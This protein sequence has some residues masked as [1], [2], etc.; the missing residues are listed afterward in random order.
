MSAHPMRIMMMTAN[1]TFAL[2]FIGQASFGKKHPQHE[3]DEINNG[4]EDIM[5]GYVHPGLMIDVHPGDDNATNDVYDIDHRYAYRS[6][7]YSPFESS[8]KTI[9]KRDIQYVYFERV[10]GGG[11]ADGPNAHYRNGGFKGVGCYRY[12]IIKPAE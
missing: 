7:E 11:D 2:F 6:K 3:N 8:G 12:A 4:G 9:K 1:K 5:V 10:A